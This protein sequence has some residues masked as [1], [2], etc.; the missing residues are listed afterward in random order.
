MRSDFKLLMLL[1]Y[2]LC[3]QLMTQKVESGLQVLSM[4]ICHENLI[5]DHLWYWFMHITV[6]AELRF[7]IMNIKYGHMP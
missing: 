1:V 5:A 7:C 6:K 2:A 4:V 3:I